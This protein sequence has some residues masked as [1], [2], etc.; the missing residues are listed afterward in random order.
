[1]NYMNV[2]KMGLL[3]IATLW[4][5][6]A[7]SAFGDIDMVNAEVVKAFAKLD[8][9]NQE[10]KF[11]ASDLDTSEKQLK[12]AGDAVDSLQKDF[13]IGKKSGKEV[14]ADLQIISADVDKAEVMISSASSDLSNLRNGLE[15]I[16]KVALN[17]ESRSL[18][19]RTNNTILI[20]RLRDQ[21][22]PM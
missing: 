5:V 21:P 20:N 2:R 14:L 12:E 16:R 1:M 19:I 15:S 8:K 11:V 13:K 3:F 4:I 17:F 9:I 7:P 6:G 18:F 10:L 22:P